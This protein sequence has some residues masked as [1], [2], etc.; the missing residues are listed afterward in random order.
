DMPPVALRAQAEKKL[1]DAEDKKV[2]KRES[3]E[4]L[5]EDTVALA[6]V[7]P[8]PAPAGTTTAPAAGEPAA[9]A[10]PAPTNA[11]APVA[12]PAVVPPAEEQAPPAEA[13][14]GADAFAQVHDNPFV[15]PLGEEARSTFSIDVDTASYAVV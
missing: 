10:A 7:P 11:P 3:K 8:A 1:S 13:E 4:S 2:G 6:V 5:A 14:H 9:A 12:A 15:A